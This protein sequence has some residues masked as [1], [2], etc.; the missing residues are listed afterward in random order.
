EAKR[1]RSAV[2]DYDDRDALRRLVEKEKPSI[3]LHVA[4]ATKGVTYADFQRANVMPTQ[5]LLDALRDAHPG[6]GRFVHVSSL[7]SY[8]PSSKSAP[9]RED[10]ARNP[11]EFYGQ[12]KLEAE[13]VV[14]SMGDALPWTI[15]RPGGVYGP[16][17]VDYFELFKSVE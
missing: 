13:Q 6:V 1:G 3:V 7:A 4:G 8:G 11:V 15:I 5:N 2:A 16:G 10:S 14:E 12:S 17:D 9:H